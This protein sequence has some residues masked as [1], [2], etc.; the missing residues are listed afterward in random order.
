MQFAFE[1]DPVLPGWLVLII[2]LTWLAAIAFVIVAAV[3]AYRAIRV[4]ERIV[5]TRLKDKSTGDRSLTAARFVPVEAWARQ[6]GMKPEQ[7]ID[8]VRAGDLKGFTSDGRWYILL[9]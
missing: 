1:L 5:Y 8:R 3:V 6:Q 4:I 7:A 9:D 2:V